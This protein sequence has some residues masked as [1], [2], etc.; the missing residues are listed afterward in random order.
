M[1]DC[2]LPLDSLF[3]GFDSST[4]SLKATV[5]DAN[6]NIVH[7]DIVNF[8]SE[9]PRYKTKDGVY[10]DP[11]VNGRIVSP[12]L[13]WVEAFELMLQRL[14]SK[15]DFGKIVAVSGSG[16]QHGSV[17]WKT[18]SSTKLLALD[19]KKPL[20]D[21]LGDAFSTKESP[22]WMD[23]STTEQCKAIEKAVGGALELSRITGSRGYERY[24]GPQ[25]RRIFET[26]PEVYNNTE[27]IS[28]VSS[29]V[30][31]LLIGAY[32]CIDETDG[33]GMN[34]MDIKQR[35][36]SKIALQA[37]APGLEEKLGT[38]A[39]AHAVAG[40]IA[41]YFVERFH[42]NKN[43]L[44]V[45]WS[46]DNPNS[47]A[48]LALNTPGDLAISLG[49]SDTVFGI[50]NDPQPSLE[51]HVFPNP[52][53]PKSYM[54]MLCYKNGSL[55]REDVRNQ[56][57]DKSWEVFA[58]FLQQTP[59]LNGGKIGFYYKE[60]EVL[61]PLPVG[62][63]RYVLENFT[64][65]TLDG[66]SEREV[67]KFDPPSE[68]RAL[69]EGQLLSLRGHAERFGM[70]SPPKRIIA[71]GGASANQSILNTV[72]AIF[73]CNVYTVQRPDSASLGAALRAAHGW[74]CNMKGSFVPIS[75]MYM[76]KLEKTSLAC[77]LSVNAGDQQLVNKYGLFMKKR[78]EIEN[79]LVQKLGRL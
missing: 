26:Q 59:P 74:L 54:V 65:D 16:Q 15:L 12:T 44:V 23:S 63:H 1:E 69:I 67:D 76:D 8:D 10:R 55:T 29:F 45:Q 19:P 50:T 28:L 52:V 21:Q 47:L 46:G 72:A 17:Y 32:A 38:L 70:P 57:A 75:C 3:L 35:A 68:V 62:F 4:Q 2:S 39:P 64:G 77:K 13:M 7:S 5:L 34:L 66:I 61:P 41:P 31:S 33:A 22:V 40:V 9:L 30:A 53:D 27:R 20:V 43:C 18:G 51:G 6:L 14:S 56:C 78:L 36:W 58:K 49:T 60:Y 71:T 73:G 79:R 11:S 42:F 24:T 25:I 48:G 37:T